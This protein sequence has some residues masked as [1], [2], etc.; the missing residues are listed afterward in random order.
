[1]NRQRPEREIEREGERVKER[2]VQIEGVRERREKKGARGSKS[3]TEEHKGVK[4]CVTV[5]KRARA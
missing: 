3:E 2:E 1:M 5:G 4:Q